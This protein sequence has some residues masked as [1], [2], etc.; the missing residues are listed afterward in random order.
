ME[1]QSPEP[2]DPHIDALLRAARPTPDPIWVR[3]AQRE[4]FPHRRRFALRLRPVGAMGFA[5]ALAV[6][7]AALLL[8]LSL[9]GVGP[10]GSGDHAVQA[11][12]RCQTVDVTRIERVPSIVTTA[13]GKVRV[14]YTRKP[15]LRRE[16]RC[17]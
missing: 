12:D 8:G 9:G 3:E 7:L 5:T 13:H 10:L 6:A 11:K 15:V 4:L 17:R 16:R 1:S 2:A 14:A